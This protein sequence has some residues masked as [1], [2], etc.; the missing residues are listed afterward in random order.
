MVGRLWCVWN[1]IFL[2]RNLF[3]WCVLSVW[4]GDVVM[5]WLSTD[6]NIGDDGAT[7]L[8]KSLSHLTQLTHLNLSSEWFGWLWL[9]TIG[10]DWLW[11]R[12]GNRIKADGATSLSQS[13]SHLTQLTNLN[14][15]GEW[16][17][18]MWCCDV[19]GCDVVIDWVQL[20]ILEMMEQ[21]H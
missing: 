12:T 5:L 6:N 17:G 11:L 19:I 16:F 7:L 3:E 14:L 20:T 2:T 15:G 13:L 10:C 8:S 21:H 1:I 4:H 9:V 18:W